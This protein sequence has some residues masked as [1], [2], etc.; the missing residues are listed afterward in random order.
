MDFQKSFLWVV[1]IALLLYYNNKFY[2]YLMYYFIVYYVMWL[3]MWFP[4]LL[5]RGFWKV[6]KKHEDAKLKNQGKDKWVGGIMI[7]T[8]LS[9]DNH[10]DRN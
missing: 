6:L 10:Y 7:V 3:V 1:V 9:Y 2:K 8:W 5:E 4:L